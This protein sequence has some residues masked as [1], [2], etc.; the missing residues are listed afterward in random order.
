MGINI[1]RMMRIRVE[2]LHELERV[3]GYIEGELRYN[4]SLLYEAIEISSKKSDECLYG[5][6]KGLS[7][8]LT[9]DMADDLS[10]NEIWN[11]SMENLERDTHLKKEDIELIRGFGQAFGYLDIYAQQNAIS[12]DK[13]RFHSS[14]VRL[15]ESLKSRMKLAFTMSALSG[16]C[17]VIIL[18]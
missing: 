9:R 5:W 8:E 16:L 18:L 1:A 3:I 7:D 11:L 4:H 14:I 13:E 15:E 6:L 2:E 12:L 10:V 17:V